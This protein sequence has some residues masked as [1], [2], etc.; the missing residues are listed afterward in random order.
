M[1]RTEPNK[2]HRTVFL[3]YG[4]TSSKTHS[5]VVQAQI[6]ISYPV[7]WSHLC[8]HDLQMLCVRTGLSHTSDSEFHLVKMQ[9]KNASHP[10]P[11]AEFSNILTTKVSLDL[12]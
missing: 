11:S 4:N 12:I 2:D 9:V 6:T 7:L 1:R 8:N 5:Q 3:A 10:S